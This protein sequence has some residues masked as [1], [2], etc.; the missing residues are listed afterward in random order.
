MDPQ[1]LVQRSIE[2]GAVITELLPQLLLRLSLGEMGGGR[3]VDA[4]PLPLR[5]HYRTT[6]GQEAGV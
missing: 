4:L 6:R 2:R 1:R 5:A 3:R